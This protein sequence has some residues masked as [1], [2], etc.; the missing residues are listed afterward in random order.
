MSIACFERV[1]AAQ[2]LQDAAGR[3][4]LLPLEQIPL[5]RR[6]TAGSAGYDFA[7]TYALSLAPGESAVIPTGIRVRMEQGWVLL[8]LPR[9]SLGFRH[10]VR[11]SN[12]VGVIDGDYYGAANEGHIL[13]KLFNGGDHPVTI[14][15][16]ERF[17][18][19]IF[20][21]FGLAQEDEDAADQ[22]RSGGLGSTGR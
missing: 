17:C 13:V 14:Q 12:T 10:N 1:S 3:E 18:Q 6:A 7:C 2:Y 20:L 11:L 8:L 21:P 5:P 9:S 16:G 22:V 4:S 19:G 15:P